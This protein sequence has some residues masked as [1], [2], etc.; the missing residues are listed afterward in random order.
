M[1]FAIIAITSAPSTA[2]FGM[3]TAAEEADAADDGRR[4]RVEED[5]AAAGVQVDRAKARREDDAAE[6][7]HHPEIMKTIRRI[8]CDVDAGAPRRLGVPADGV[9]VA[10]EGR[11]VG[12]EAS[13]R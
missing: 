10:P 11:A 5:R 6:G 8:R 12:E 13:R 7:G 9:D 3:A 1:P 2:A 4:D